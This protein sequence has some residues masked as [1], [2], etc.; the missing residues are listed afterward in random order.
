M[1]VHMIREN[2]NVGADPDGVCL[3]S[4]VPELIDGL[5]GD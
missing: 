1:K 3:E 2:G 5:S 4:G